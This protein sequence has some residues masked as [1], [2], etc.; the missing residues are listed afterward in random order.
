MF[1][2]EP[3]FEVGDYLVLNRTDPAIAMTLEYDWQLPA[4]ERLTSWG[5]GHVLKV[6]ATEDEFLYEL[7]HGSKSIWVAEDF[8]VKPSHYE[9]F[10]D[11]VM[12]AIDQISS[13]LPAVTTVEIEGQQFDVKFFPGHD[14]LLAHDRPSIRKLL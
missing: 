7:S 4:E 9:Q 10:H 11:H 1:V 14:D 13:Q 12:A 8:L 5:G 3:K 6:E 2:P